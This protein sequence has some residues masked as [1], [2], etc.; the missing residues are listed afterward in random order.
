V[1]SPATLKIQD[2]PRVLPRRRLEEA[3]VH[4]AHPEGGAQ[5]VGFDHL[6]V[7]GYVDSQDRQRLPM[8]ARK[9]KLFFGTQRNWDPASVQRRTT[10]SGFPCS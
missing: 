3:P 8:G 1:P 6:A 4:A 10:I 7:A 5:V 9:S 2:P